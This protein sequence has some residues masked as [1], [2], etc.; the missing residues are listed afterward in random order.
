MSRVRR[1]LRR[2]ASFVRLGGEIPSPALLPRFTPDCAG[3]AEELL[4]KTGESKECFVAEAGLVRCVGVTSFRPERMALSAEAGV[5]AAFLLAERLAAG[6][7][8][9][10][11]AAGFM[12]S[13]P[14]RADFAGVFFGVAFGLGL[15]AA[16]AGGA[17]SSSETEASASMLKL[18]L[19]AAGLGGADSLPLSLPFGMPFP[20]FHGEP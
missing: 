9:V 5:T 19:F 16:G 2:G 4:R 6:T 1:S 14:E 13:R 11:C 10:L 20:P 7:A 18:T 3:F 15:A 12:A 8:G 17:I